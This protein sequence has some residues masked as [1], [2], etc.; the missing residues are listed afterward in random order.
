MRV[1]VV[2]GGGREHAL[3]WKLFASPQ[4]EAIFCA[5]GNAGTTLM[6]QSVDVDPLDF[7][8]L[9]DAVARA[10]IDLVVVGPE[11]PLAAGLVD[12]L[13]ERGARV[14]G[15]S[16]AAA[17]IEASKAWT[18]ELLQRHGIPTAV[19]RT[20][21]SLE[22]GMVAVHELGPRCVVKADGLAAGKGV[23][24]ADTAEEAEAALRALLEARALGDA[25]A[26]VVVEERLEGPELSVLLVTD[27]E[28]SVLMPPARDYKRLKDGD[29]GP[30]TGGMGGYTR[31]PDVS[32]AL[33]DSIQATIIGP[34]LQAMAAE[35]RPYKGV[36]YAG[37]MLTADGPRVLE[38]NCRFGDPEAQLILPLLESDFAELCL[39][40]AEGHLDPAS[41]R[42]GGGHTCGV[43]LAA[44]GYPEAPRTGAPIKGLDDLPPGVIA[45]HGGTRLQQGGGLFRGGGRSVVT[46]GGRVLTVVATAPTLEH[47][48]SLVYENLDTLDFAGKQFRT[49]IG[50]PP[51]GSPAPAPRATLP[52]AN[53]LETIVPTPQKPSAPQANAP[54]TPSLATL[55]AALSD[56]ADFLL[57]DAE[58]RLDVQS[59][60]R[61]S[62][63]R[64][65]VRQALAASSPVSTS[66]A[67]GADLVAS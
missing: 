65:R 54:S 35:G 27:G 4:V 19:S 61:A 36:L 40:V 56:A 25:G 38:Y 58:S 50:I 43:V 37:L 18:K 31:P 48:R 14:F 23:F 24:V 12:F 20:V 5:P 28:R 1:L 22:A 30:N 29:Q 63:L 26:R 34:T 47:A 45:F 39:Q 11:A 10:G 67:P 52:R 64:T 51:V 33:L 55:A 6:A 3:V 41:V 32:D 62:A 66:A 16:R 60:A 8:K 9:G 53:L 59:A 49:D 2:G 42:W 7:P 46:A 13:E 17:Q 44:E 57:E 15:P 21:D